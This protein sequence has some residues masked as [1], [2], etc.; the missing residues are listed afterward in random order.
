MEFQSPISTPTPVKVFISS[1]TDAGNFNI[2]ITVVE[3]TDPMDFIKGERTIYT[4]PPK[5]NFSK[6]SSYRSAN[7]QSDMNRF[8]GF[9]VD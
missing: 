7:S 1:K 8:L 5:T 2:N 9:Y 3:T 4:I 6:I